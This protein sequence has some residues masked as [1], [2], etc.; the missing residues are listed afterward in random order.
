VRES[1]ENPEAL[2]IFFDVNAGKK[3]LT[4]QALPTLP[5]Q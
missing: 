5:L 1:A 2:K 4:S 3:T